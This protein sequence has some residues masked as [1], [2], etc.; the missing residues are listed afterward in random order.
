M[1]EPRW[2]MGKQKWLTKPRWLTGES[3][4]LTARVANGQ[5]QDGCLG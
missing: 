5:L 2:L 3:R 4:W 1:S